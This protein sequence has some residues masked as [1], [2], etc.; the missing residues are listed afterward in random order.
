MLGTQ[1]DAT[2]FETLFTGLLQCVHS[3]KQ[4]IV[5]KSKDA[6][7]SFISTTS[8]HSKAITLLCLAL[9]DRNPQSRHLAALYMDVFL[10]KHAPNTLVR[11]NM[12]G[13]LNSLKKMELFLKTGLMDATPAVRQV[14]YGTFWIYRKYWPSNG[15]R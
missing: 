15:D 8:Y 7:I 3:S 5:N 11:E 13:S 6:M 2:T 4:L 10:Q 12:G 1:L 14:C 9:D